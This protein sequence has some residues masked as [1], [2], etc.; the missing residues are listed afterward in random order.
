MPMDLAVARPYTAL[1]S[2]AQARCGAL[3]PV[4]EARIMALP[5]AGVNARP[6]V[7]TPTGKG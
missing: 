3:M 4:V 5:L 1:R 7:V 6:M 2:M